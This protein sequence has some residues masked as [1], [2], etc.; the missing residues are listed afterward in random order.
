[1]AGKPWWRETIETLAYALVMALIIRTFIVQAFW[2]PSGSMVPTLEPGDRVLVCKFWYRFFEPKRGQI[3]VFR[4][5]Y[6]TSKDFIKRVV[7]LPGDVVE[8]SDGVV[9]LNGKRLDEPYVFH[10]DRYQMSPVRVPEGSYFVMGDNR[11]NSQDSRFWGFVPKNLILG[12]AFFRY[13]PLTR[14]GL[15]R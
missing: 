4:F 5:P 12:P 6:D 1:M 15:V 2:I 11:P 8:I 9:F 14:L 3:V 7:G 10:R 13:W